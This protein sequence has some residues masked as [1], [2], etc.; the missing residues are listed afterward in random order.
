MAKP[1]QQDCIDFHHPLP[2]TDTQDFLERYRIEAEREID[3]LLQRLNELVCTCCPDQVNPGST[4][5]ASA[6]VGWTG[7]L[8]ICS[9]VSIVL[10]DVLP[11][12][13]NGVA[14]S[15]TVTAGGSAKT[16]TYIITSGALPTGLALNAST[17]AIVGTP[18]AAATFTFTVTAT[19]T[20]GCAGARAY[21]VTI[22]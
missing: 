15:G 12:G 3:L 13:T 19:D 14:Y 17:G 22:A 4:P 5:V 21:S 2:P 8:A 1:L 11:D 9:G 16:I 20:D 18:S 7:E 10:D 6:G